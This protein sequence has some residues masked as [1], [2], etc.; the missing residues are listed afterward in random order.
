M[1]AILGIVWAVVGFVVS[2]VL[3]W[4]IPVTS[5]FYT[6]IVACA[7]LWPFSLPFLLGYAALVAGPKS[8]VK[9]YKKE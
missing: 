1:V 9:R 5:K 8:L 4:V 6:W 7:A 3:H 2:L